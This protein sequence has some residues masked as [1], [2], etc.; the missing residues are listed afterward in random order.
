MT[1]KTEK[2]NNNSSPDR[3]SF[4]NWLWLGLGGVVLVEVIWM[5]SAFLRPHKPAAQQGDFGSEID[6]GPVDGFQPNTV[7]ALPRGHFY[8]ACLPDH[9][10]ILELVQ[11]PRE[12]PYLGR[13]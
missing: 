8:L 2:N 12:Q 13:G 9:V 5:V 3:R 6:A 4:L 7:T 11:L 1:N 10:N